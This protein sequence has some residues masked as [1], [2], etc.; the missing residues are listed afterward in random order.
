MPRG[1]PMRNVVFVAPYPLTTTLRF[2]EALQGLQDVRLLGLFQQ[3][4]QGHHAAMFADVVCVE[5]AL[6][7]GSI[8]GGLATLQQRHGPTHRLLGVLEDLQEPLA[9]LRAH[10]GIDGPTPAIAHRFRD[11]GHMKDA[12]RA[13]G[14]PCARHAR[15]QNADDA[16]RFI[17]QVGFPVVL[18]P[19][20]GAG[21]IATFRVD[22]FE[23][24]D[25]ALSV[26][27]PTPEREVLAEEFLT[28]QEFSF[29]TLTVAGTPVFHSI[30]R[31][32]PSPLEVLT[33]DWVQWIV[34]L[35]RDIS[36]PEFDPVRSVG[37]RTIEALGLVDGMTHMEWFRRPDGSVAIGEI[38]A[39]PP[40]AQIVRLMS[41]AHEA[42]LYR[43]WARAVVDQAFDGPLKRHWS[44]GAAFLRGQGRGRIVA[45]EGIEEAQARMGQLV[46]AAKLPQVGAHKAASYEGDGWV[47]VRHEDDQVVLSALLDLVRTVRIRYA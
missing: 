42:D 45:V 35:P 7:A 12:L 47:V 39:R 10:M 29:E 28:G 4:P 25:E 16:W 38:A 23:A 44:C 21:A 27:K 6:H 36:G 8:A 32:Y 24:L 30:G 11:K 41:T 5:S 13:A 22:S 26:L 34:H 40:G 2:C 43:G 9:E 46:T 3:A 19:P 14:L 31:Y 1:K 15:L 18:K 37:A 17:Q 33:Q 20:A